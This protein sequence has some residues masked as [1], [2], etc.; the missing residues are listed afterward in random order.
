[1]KTEM[2][3][4]EFVGVFLPSFATLRKAGGVLRWAFYLFCCYVVIRLLSGVT[5]EGWKALGLLAIKFV[6][7]AIAIVGLGAW[8]YGRFLQR[9]SPRV[10]AGVQVAGQ[11]FTAVS[12][13]A[14]G[15]VLYHVWLRE[16]AEAV[17]GAILIGVM[18]LMRW[19]EAPR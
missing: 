2:S 15:A 12:L 5:F 14:L 13:M 8:A 16:P 19:F 6:I 10:L 1:M 17:V 9:A 11:A 3:R 7:P 4:R 18:T